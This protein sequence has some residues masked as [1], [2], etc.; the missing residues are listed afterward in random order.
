MR[1][2]IIKILLIWLVAYLAG[3]SGIPVT[4]GD[5]TINH[6]I[7]GL[8]V[9]SVHHPA[10]K[11]AATVIKTQT[12]GLSVSNQPGIKA[13]VGYAS[14]SA[15]II[16]DGTQDF[17]AEISQRP[18]SALK[19]ESCVAPPGLPENSDDKGEKK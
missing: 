13:S 7:I 11:G 15:I 1:P 17:C 5:G 16:P 19:M 3:C 6:L 9:V 14:N 4:S 12:L 2:V 8:G 10:G 18:F